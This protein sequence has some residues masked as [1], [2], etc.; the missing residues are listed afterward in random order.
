MDK[1]GRIRQ[2]VETELHEYVS[3]FDE[4]LRHEDDL[5]G[6]AL[7]YVGARKG[8]MMRPILVLLVAK[9]LGPVVG[10]A[11]LRSAVTLE[12]LHTASL[13]HDDVVD[14]SD[15][16]RGQASVNAVF[17]NKVAVLVGDYLLSEALDQA[18][19]T[20]DLAIV[21]TIARLGA[22]L[23]EGEVFQ[24]S[25]IREQRATEE[26]YF[27]IIRSKTAALFAACTRIAAISA[28]G[29]E[30]FTRQ[31][32]R[33]G[34]IVG[35]CFQIRDDI[36]DYYDD[37]AIGK[38]TGNDLREGKLT[39]PLLY[40]LGQEGGEA[41]D[42]EVRRVKEGTAG[43]DDIARLIDFAKR[44]GGI[45]YAESVMMRLREE[46]TALLGNFKNDEVRATLAAYLD[47]VIARNI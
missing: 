7:K 16:R 36:F 24:L 2:P 43:D 26:A 46:G 10:E 28:G 45:A 44:R 12:L 5:L 23:S 11:S 41:M 27:R 29:D 42:D 14:E 3:L 38:P 20:G 32:T 13:V 8:K 34:E 25:N 22:T 19:R 47:F 37:A 15:E 30:E 17:G 4:A 6:R 31:A 1:L 21:R 40:A 35:E 9:E 39:L 18:A 33:F